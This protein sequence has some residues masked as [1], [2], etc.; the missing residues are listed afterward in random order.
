[1]RANI[2]NVGCFF[3][4]TAATLLSGARRRCGASVSPALRLTRMAKQPLHG[5]EGLRMVCGANSARP[6]LTLISIVLTASRRTVPAGRGARCS[7]ATRARAR[8][9]QGPAGCQRAPCG[10]AHAWAEVCRGVCAGTAL[11][12]FCAFGS[13]GKEPERKAPKAA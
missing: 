11:L 10:F 8:H 12:A 5:P 2:G 9:A 4:G 3:G 7:A 13:L 1:M 6:A